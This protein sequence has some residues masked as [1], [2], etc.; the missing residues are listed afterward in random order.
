M[1]TISI[2][3]PQALSDCY[4]NKAIIEELWCGGSICYVRLHTKV[5]LQIY[6]SCEFK[7]LIK[8]NDTDPKVWTGALDTIN[9][10]FGES[11]NTYILKLVSWF[12]TLKLS[13]EPR[14]WNKLSAVDI[15]RLVCNEHGYLNI[16]AQHLTQSPVKHKVSRQWQQN[17]YQFLRQLLVNSSIYFRL[18]D[19]NEN[20][21]LF[22]YNDIQ[23][24][25]N[26]YDLIIRK[27]HNYYAFDK[28][29]K[30]D[31]RLTTYANM[32]L[33]G[34]QIHED[35]DIFYIQRVRHVYQKNS[36]L[37]Y[38]NYIWATSCIVQNSKHILE[39]TVVAGYCDRTH[40][41]KTI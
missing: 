1:A 14:V 30:Q 17:S 7:L 37:Q 9:Q 20:T 21:Y 22:L 25:F 26:Q 16:N 2:L 39:K 4:A 38:Y 6:R 40:K 28:P 35:D 41:S 8:A 36:D 19:C 10:Q 5:N 27:R 3:H 29:Y 18:A 24:M 11:L 33:P 31:L 12:D 32:S 23:D 15:L 34:M 13:T